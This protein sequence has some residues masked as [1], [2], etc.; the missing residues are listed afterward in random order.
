LIT[1]IR[2]GAVSSGRSS[3]ELRRR[4][5]DRDQFDSPPEQARAT[6][7]CSVKDTGYAGPALYQ[8]HLKD[9]SH[10][11]TANGT[12]TFQIVANPPGTFSVET[13]QVHYSIVLPPG[14]TFEY[15]EVESHGEDVA[16]LIG[17]KGVLYQSCI[18]DA[19]DSEY[20]TIQVEVELQGREYQLTGT[21]KSVPPTVITLGP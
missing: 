7:T 6:I 12:A 13:A 10:T 17:T 14:I 21:I 3:E 18:L 11:T 16:Y 5:L 2:I 19:L 1:S 15:A 20:S 4:S 9:P 8:V